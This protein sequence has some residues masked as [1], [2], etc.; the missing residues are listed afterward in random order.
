MRN[1]GGRTRVA[2]I[3]TNMPADL[4][5]TTPRMLTRGQQ[6][7]SSTSS[8]SEMVEP[9]IEIR[10]STVIVIRRSAVT[11]R[12]E[13]DAGTSTTKKKSKK[14]KKCKKKKKSKKKKAKSLK[15]KKKKLRK[16]KK[17]SHSYSSS[18]SCSSSHS[19]SS[20]S[21]LSSSSSSSSGSFVS[22][23]SVREATN[24]NTSGSKPQRSPR[25]ERAAASSKR[26]KEDENYQLNALA[27]AAAL[28]SAANEAEVGSPTNDVQNGAPA[29]KTFSKRVSPPSVHQQLASNLLHRLTRIA[30]RQQHRAL[31]PLAHILHLRLAHIIPKAVHLPPHRL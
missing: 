31:Q 29:A 8:N 4:P 5:S 25:K 19:S 24:K 22:V 21:S 17:K 20:S 2:R 7:S 16:R 26:R 30:Q 12:D 10:Q 15:S 23:S 6:G 1:G 18:D 11:P 3:A 27:T 28:A 9:T 14:K 13:N